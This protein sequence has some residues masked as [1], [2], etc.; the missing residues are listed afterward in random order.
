MENWK[1]EA[2]KG[3]VHDDITDCSNIEDKNRKLPTDCQN[4][5][6]TI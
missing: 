6:G 1:I 4:F 3:E 2:N 5:K